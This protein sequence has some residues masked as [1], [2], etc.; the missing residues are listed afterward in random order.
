MELNSKSVLINSIKFFFITVAVILLGL[1][2]SNV[3]VVIGI[4]LM[5]LSLGLLVYNLNNSYSEYK[6]VKH[7]EGKVKNGIALE[8]YSNSSKVKKSITMFNGV[9]EGE[10]KEFYKNGRVRY[11]AFYIKGKKHGSAQQFFEDGS[12]AFE[13]TYENGVQKGDTLVFYNN[14]SVYREFTLDDREQYGRIIEYRRN[15]QIKFTWDGSQ[16]KFYNVHGELSSEIGIEFSSEYEFSSYSSD[17]RNFLTKCSPSGPWYDYN[18]DGSIKN[19]YVFT[20]GFHQDEQGNIK[21]DITLNIGSELESTFY[22]SC[23][24]VKAFHINFISDCAINRRSE[25]VEQFNTTMM[26]PPGVYNGFSAEYFDI[27]TIGDILQKD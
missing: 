16:I 1:W 5:I 14:G 24:L 10:Y 2:L 20:D 11:E 4:V 21:V 26:G 9:R 12:I 13:T 7:S 22:A 3:I 8:L 15:G 19:Q 17:W 27:F 18:R 25:N 23:R 6:R